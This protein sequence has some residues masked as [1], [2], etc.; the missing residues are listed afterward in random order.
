MTVLREIFTNEYVIFPLL[1]G[2]LA[3]LY[4]FFYHFAREGRPDFQW[5]ITT[6]GMP[7]SH[8]AS[9]MSLST[10]IGL[11]HGFDSPLFGL[12]LFFSLI[13]M[14][15]AAGLRR[16]AGEQAA[17]INKMLEEFSVSHT[18]REERLRELLGHT[19]TE[20]LVGALA[21]IV[22]SVIFARLFP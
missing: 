22:A 5:L 7:S 11:R 20:V 10:L 13:I 19:P 15:D 12:V 21:G 2:V 4:K 9:V 18:I 8:S 16:A 1:I 14:Y 3:Q 17:V 6:G